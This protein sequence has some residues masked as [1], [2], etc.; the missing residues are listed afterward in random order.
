MGDGDETLI[1]RQGR[2]LEGGSGAAD[3]ADANSWIAGAGGARV[4]ASLFRC[5][6]DGQHDRRAPVTVGCGH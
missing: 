1:S 4:I 6:F 5:P 2:L 3:P